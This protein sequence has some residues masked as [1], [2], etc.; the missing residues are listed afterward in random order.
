M[1]VIFE[2]RIKFNPL[3]DGWFIEL[4]DTVE[5]KVVKCKD[6]EEFEKSIEELGNDYGGRIDEVRW[7]ADENVPQAI[8]NE[9]RVGLEHF[10]KEEDPS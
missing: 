3:S 4:T 7:S 8:I 1:S 10:K 6:L 9:I 5:G 2:S